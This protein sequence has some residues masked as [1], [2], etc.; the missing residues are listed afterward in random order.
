V[1]AGVDNVC[2]V[3][4]H[5]RAGTARS[6]LAHTISGS[7]VGQ[8][9]CNGQEL[10]ELGLSA[11]LAAHYGAVPMLATG[12]DTLAREAES[13]VPG[14][15]TAVV[16]T[17]FGNR[18]AQG[19]HPNEACARIEAA[20]TRPLEQAGEVKAPRFDGAVDLEVDVLRPSMIELACLIPGVELRGSLT[21]AFHAADFAAAYNLI[22][23]FC[24][25][26]TAT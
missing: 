5:G 7:V 3:G 2:F 1:D 13:V 8:L 11:A 21:L 24:V 9:R 14:I 15:T 12:D 10:G 19:V 17:A 23:V 4:Y 25:L 26:A 20:A 6:V 22:D 18:A 16:K